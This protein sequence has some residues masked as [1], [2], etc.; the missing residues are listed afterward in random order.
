MLTKETT[1]SFQSA[2]TVA[3]ERLS[4]KKFPSVMTLQEL[5]GVN[6]G[7]ERKADRLCAKIIG[8]IAHQMRRTFVLNI[9]EISLKNQ[10]HY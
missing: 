8:H 9:K 7:T 4:Y 5:N 3:K 10:H 1:I 6:V 2:Y